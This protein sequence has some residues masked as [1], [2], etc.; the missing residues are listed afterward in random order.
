MM[1]AK[2]IFKVA[3]AAVLIGAGRTLGKHAME[4][5]KDYCWR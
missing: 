2:I 4:E 3:A 1:I 5:L